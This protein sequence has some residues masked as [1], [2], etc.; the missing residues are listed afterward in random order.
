MTKLEF[1]ALRDGKIVSDKSAFMNDFDSNEIIVQI[2]NN[3]I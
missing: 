2:C 1:H 3:N